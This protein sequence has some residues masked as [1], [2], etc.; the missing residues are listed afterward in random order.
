MKI[1]NSNEDAYT[2][3][4]IRVNTESVIGHKNGWVKFRLSTFVISIFQ[5]LSYEDCVKEA[6]E[7]GAKC[8][9][10]NVSYLKADINEVCDGHQEKLKRLCSIH[11]AKGQTKS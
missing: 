7:A 3:F 4:Q 8:R 5:Y 6:Y 11:C 9:M 10:S 2:L 1:L